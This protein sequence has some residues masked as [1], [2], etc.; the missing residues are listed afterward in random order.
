VAVMTAQLF[1][2]KKDN[3]IELF[4]EGGATRFESIK[5]WKM[6]SAW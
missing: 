2:D 6:R 5:L 3:G 1:P 4:S